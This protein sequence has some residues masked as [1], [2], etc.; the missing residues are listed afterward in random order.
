MSMKRI[1]KITMMMLLVVVASCSVKHNSGSQLPPEPE[2]E[3]YVVTTSQLNVRATASKKGAKVG[4]FFKGDTIYVLDKHR[5][6]YAVTDRAQ[7]IAGFVSKKFVKKVEEP[8]TA[9]DEVAGD[10]QV[11]DIGEAVAGVLPGSNIAF[12]DAD[13]LITPEMREQLVAAAA[14]QPLYYIIVAEDKV[15]VNKITDFASDYYSRYKKSTA[16][17]AHKDSMA[18]VCLLGEHRLIQVDGGAS[19]LK[20]MR[21]LRSA[22]YWNMQQLG[23]NGNLAAGMTG[24]M[25][26]LADCQRAY[27]SLGWWKRW[28]CFS[29]NMLDEAC[30][31][32]I[33]DNILPRDGFWHKYVFGWLMAI[34]FRLARH[35]HAITDSVV[36]DITLLGLLIVLINIGV[37]LY[38]WSVLR[39]GKGLTNGLAAVGLIKKLLV[40]V[41]WL[42]LS[43]LAIYM[44][45]DATK[46]VLMEAVGYPEPDIMGL[47]NQLS[48]PAL[49]K[50]WI[51]VTAYLAIATFVAAFNPEWAFKAGLPAGAQRSIYASERDAIRNNII[52]SNNEVNIEKRMRELDE[53]QKPYGIL[54]TSGGSGAGNVIGL[55]IPMMFVING[56]LL[57]YLLLFQIIR[58]ATG[59]FRYT[60]MVAGY[61]MNERLRTKRL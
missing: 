28:N 42:T 15:P 52:V 40:F 4:V 51:M 12:E 2:G 61:R 19:A 1:V 32:F 47:A 54:A 31:S 43:S 36:W 20:Y 34:P 27:D 25:T 11:S 23:L 39:R 21:T 6:W 44:T 26:L 49:E 9:P 29:S 30:D 33:A 46:V 14:G 59:V 41:S 37:E 10:K 57:L 55:G 38:A 24:V 13:N 3:K 48:R 60:A 18:V 35:I 56:T 22:D 5:K 17:K 53:A 50:N 7:S 16:Y 45:I 58:M 8:V